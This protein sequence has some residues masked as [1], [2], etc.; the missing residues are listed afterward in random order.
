M[1]LRKASI[2]GLTS[3]ASVGVR[4]A[5]LGTVPVSGENMKTAAKKPRQ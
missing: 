1:G 4:A 3:G 5:I 2:L